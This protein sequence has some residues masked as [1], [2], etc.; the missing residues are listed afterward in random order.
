MDCF[1]GGVVLARGTTEPGLYNASRVGEGTEEF[2][3]RLLL[4]GQG[5]VRGAAGVKVRV[6]DV[7]GVKAP[8][9]D[10][11]VGGEKWVVGVEWVVL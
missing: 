9:W 3:T 8:T 7:V 1:V 2:G 11:H 10:I 4:A 6:G 5:G